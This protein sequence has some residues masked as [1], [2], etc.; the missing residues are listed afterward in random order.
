VPIGRPVES[1]FL[2]CATRSLPDVAFV[3]PRF[4]DEGSGTS[5]D[6]HPHADVRNG[7][8]FLYSVYRAVTTS[9]AWPRTLLILNFDEW[10][11]FFDHVP[12]PTR[13][14]PPATRAAGD[15]DGRLGFRVPCV[16]ISPWAQRAHVSTR[17]YDHT[18]V[19]RLI[20]SRFGLQPL[21]V[22]DAQ[23]ND[24][25]AELTGTPD[26]R[27]PDYAVPAGPF[28]G[29]CGA[30]PASEEEWAPLRDLAARSGWPV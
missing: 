18:S 14:L 27:A 15:T 5:G 9:P 19:L 8:A 24:L 12:P 22:R 2:D 30:G 17:A 13:P 10:G 20:E 25:T 4:E 6:D 1:F 7:E 11:G 28:G 21:T 16:L 26:A 3:D 29:A 23:A